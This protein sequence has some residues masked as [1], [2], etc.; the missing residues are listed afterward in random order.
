MLAQVPIFKKKIQQNSFL[1]LPSVKEGPGFVV[2]AKISTGSQQ[3][4]LVNNVASSF[5]LRHISPQIILSNLP[6]D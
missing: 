4:E 2:E 1:Y 5:G 6:E 3:M